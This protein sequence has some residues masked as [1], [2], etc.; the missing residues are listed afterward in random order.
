MTDHRSPVQPKPTP[1]IEGE[2]GGPGVD[3]AASHLRAK[4]A[5]H[6]RVSEV[7]YDGRLCCE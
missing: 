5:G 2:L 6:L 1:A 4:G 3:L 7:R